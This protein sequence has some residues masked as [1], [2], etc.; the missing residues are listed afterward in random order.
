MKPLRLQ[1][2]GKSLQGEPC[3][4][5]RGPFG[6]VSRESPVSES[7][8][9]GPHDPRKVDES[10][11]SEGRIVSNR[12]TSRVETIGAGEETA[13]RPLPIDNWKPSGPEWTYTSARPGSSCRREVVDSPGLACDLQTKVPTVSAVPRQ[14]GIAAVRKSS[15]ICVAAVLRERNRVSGPTSEAAGE[16]R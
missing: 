4:G 13:N 9:P 1:R 3:R 6:Q 2:V 8:G 16:P 7:F 10:P 5:G 11:D 14:P 12:S 15:G